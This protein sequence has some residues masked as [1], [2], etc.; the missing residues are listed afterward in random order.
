MASLALSVVA[1]LAPAD[2]LSDAA[3]AALK[4]FDANDATALKALAAK[5]EPDPWLVAHEL[6]ARGSP[7]AALVFARAS[8]RP[9]TEGLPAYVASLKGAKLTG[10]GAAALAEAMK[11]LA[12]GQAEESLRAIE[13]APPEPG[14]W[15]IRLT[16]ARGV[17]LREL[18]RTEEAGVALRAAAEAAEELGWHSRA[19]TAW[20]HAGYTAFVASR[21]PDA[22]P[23]YERALAAAERA[24]DPAQIAQ[25]LLRL[26]EAL[27]NMGHDRD[28]VAPLRRAVAIGEGLGNRLEYARSLG[29]LA[30]AL[31]GSGETAEALAGYERTLAL[32]EELRDQQGIALTLDRIGGMHFH[33]GDAEKALDFYGRAYR[34]T[35]SPLTLANMGR[36]HAA[37]GRFD[38]AIAML[39]QALAEVEE[40]GDL[41]NTATILVNLG[42][43]RRAKG[44]FTS[45]FSLFDRALALQQRMGARGDEANT[46]SMIASAH[47]ERGDCAAAILVYEQA[48]VLARETGD[49]G[50]IAFVL[51]NMA[52]V[53]QER[54]DF[55]RALAMFRE[56]R[57][58]FL[59]VGDRAGNARMLGNIGVVHH[60][61][62]EY[63][64]ALRGFEAAL[65]EH[66]AMDDPSSVAT[67]LGNIGMVH[68]HLGDVPTALGFFEQQIAIS[69]RLGERREVTTAM[70]NL[71]L[72][73]MELDRLGDAGATLEKALAIARETGL[74]GLEAS[75]CGHLGTALER[76]GDYPEA[77]LRFEAALAL[78][79]A[80]GDR[81]GAA[82]TLASLATVSRRRRDAE[83]AAGYA[84]EAVARAQE[85]ESPRVLACALAESAW[86]DLARGR[87]AE[88]LASSLR[89][90]GLVARL[91]GGLDERR[92]AL[93]REIW[94][95]SFEVGVRA[96]RALGDVEQACFLLEAGRAG[97]LLE[98][99]GGR[100]R[101]RA[102]LV[103]PVLYEAEARARE[104]ENVARK[105]YDAA[106]KA[107]D[108]GGIARTRK[109][110]GEARSAVDAAVGRVQVE[111]KAAADIVYTK[112][113]SLPEIQAALA[114]GEALVL[115]ALLRPKALALVVTRAEARVVELGPTADIA[116]ACRAGA[117]A[118]AAVAARLAKLLVGPLGLGSGT[119]RLLVA[120]QG[121]LAYVPFVLL[122]GDR[123]VAY[124][125]SA[126]TH[127]LLLESGAEWG[128]GVLAL[129]D[130][131]SP[132]GALPA[133]RK[134]AEA[135]GDVVLL[136]AEATETGLATAVAARPRWRA[137][138]LACHGV[139]D[140]D[141][142]LRTSLALAPDA[143]QDGQLTLLE[144]FRLK[145][146]ADL[147]VLSACETA[148][149][150]VYE[151]E[152]VMGLV[153]GFM[154][155]GAP[156]VIVS[157]WDV[158]DA[159]TAALMRRFYGLWNPRDGSKGLPAATAL[160][161]A[162][163]L[164]ASQEEWEHPRFWAAWQLWE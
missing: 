97:T 134:E 127:L 142:P 30:M 101:L 59:R 17:V 146:P 69:V 5:S 31:E 107:G 108:R 49:P 44:D 111:A 118:D 54:A 12:A 109:A 18:R 139:F 110:L 153:R 81:A 42:I 35:R 91:A 141:H 138:H 133:A 51:G 135:V 53:H 19:A 144:I 87:T 4:A 163:A 72:A 40:G 50:A 116:E 45:A 61:L 55:R 10:A 92:G 152:G 112:V 98:S 66:R 20:L 126:T 37:Q 27:S 82:M 103:P 22:P 26:G 83:R 94:K 60:S 137:V 16:Y 102:D 151:A 114:E 159:A 90:V 157:L 7:E 76:E 32:M 67:A 115:Y 147:V 3:D 140:P 158:D 13:S 150:E 71:A 78:N 148:K 145:V 86:A 106:L 149:G 57:D 21:Y 130:P 64:D 105:D 38:E 132:M 96:A 9:A 164:V 34:A 8:P 15:S 120:P 24:G 89:C 84:A 29:A 100:E 62:G 73:Q 123:D 65:A 155:A 119:T 33:A 125:P 63:A 117:E 11:A 23:L 160:R 154:L 28:A 95:D 48:L 131:A 36:I 80:V 25:V 1:A 122:S 104:A 68:L 39:E 136:G 88:A 128:D 85:L 47:M 129:G 93:A 56:A 121:V 113:R 156:R 2:E 43:A 161:K 52:I 70:E 6:C 46:L 124:V 14:L 143:Q 162:Q 99:L 41:R 58:L 74:K 79:D 77:A 75:I